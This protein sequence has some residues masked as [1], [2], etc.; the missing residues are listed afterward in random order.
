PF[1]PLNHRETVGHFT[2]PLGPADHEEHR[3]EPLTNSRTARVLVVD[4]EPSISDVVATSLRLVGHEADVTDHGHEAMRLLATGRYDLVVLD[5]MLPDTDGI[6]ICRRIRRDDPELPI[7]FVTARTDAADAAEGLRAG[8]D[9]YVRK[10]FH[11]DE[12]VARVEALLRRGKGTSADDDLLHFDDIEIDLRRYEVRRGGHLLDLT[13]T[14]LRLLT[15]L[16]HNRG[17]I[18]TRSQIVDLTWDEPGAVDTTTVET[19][20]SRLRRKLEADLG[21]SC[22]VTRRGV[23]YGLMPRPTTKET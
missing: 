15:A 2:C 11:I 5:V 4:D 12:L 3:D 22:L 8:G 21:P 13:P 17:R 16:V 6:E 7:L 23:G 9:D 19:V 1:A 18:L 14:E 20:V 10:P